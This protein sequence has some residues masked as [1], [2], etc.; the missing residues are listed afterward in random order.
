[1]SKYCLLSITHISFRL[2]KWDCENS[3]WCAHLEYIK[4]HDLDLEC[5]KKK[6]PGTTQH[7][8]EKS[9]A[10]SIILSH[11]V[12]DE[13]HTGRRR[14]NVSLIQMRMI[15]I[16]TCRR[17]M[18]TDRDGRVPCLCLFKR[19]NIC[20]V[21]EF[22]RWVQ[23]GGKCVAPLFL[24]HTKNLRKTFWC[25]SGCVLETMH[26]LCV[27]WWLC[28]R[29][30][31][32]AH[33]LW[34]LDIEMHLWLL[35]HACIAAHHQ[36]ILCTHT[37]ANVNKWI[38]ARKVLAHAHIHMCVGYIY[39]HVCIYSQ[40]FSCMGTGNTLLSFFSRNYASS[41]QFVNKGDCLF[42][43]ACSILSLTACRQA[44]VSL[45][46]TPNMCPLSAYMENLCRT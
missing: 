38:Y 33:L 15:R 1:M 11:W 3:V 46:L 10:L 43:H 40:S 7:F 25:A 22:V 16:F 27:L 14:R 23:R 5:H 18:R 21:R 41:C 8:W 31:C 29:R 28:E 30:V 13:T 37:D 44:V 24:S 39:V 34:L 36:I 12:S 20:R 45:L 32:Q 4:H 19:M 6:Q 9:N 35:P 2:F 17:K 42:V 26:A